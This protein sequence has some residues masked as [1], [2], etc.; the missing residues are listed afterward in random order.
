MGKPVRWGTA[1]A[2]RDGH[3]HTEAEFGEQ[4]PPP[5]R[6]IRW[7]DGA[8]ARVSFERRVFDDTDR[9]PVG[10]MRGTMDWEDGDALGAGTSGA[11]VRP[12]R[13]AVVPRACSI[14]GGAALPLHQRIIELLRSRR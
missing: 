6:R 12:Q 1:H 10:R 2:V 7:N 8:N 11:S 5:L 3:H 4:P 14:A 13:A 9:P